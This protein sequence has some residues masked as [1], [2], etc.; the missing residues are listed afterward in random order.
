MATAKR[1]VAHFAA[2]AVAVIAAVYGVGGTGGSGAGGPWAGI[3]QAHT[4]TP[5]TVNAR[6][7]PDAAVH[8]RWHKL[9]RDELAAPAPP[10]DGERSLDFIV[11]W[12]V[13][14]AR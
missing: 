6:A 11:R 3:R 8:R 4:Q 12:H 9:S 2:V 14:G 5:A 13:C 7:Q 10:R 1:V